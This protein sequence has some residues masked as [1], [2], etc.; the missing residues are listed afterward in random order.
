MG[1]ILKEVKFEFLKFSMTE[2][3]NVTFKYRWLFNR[4]TPW[5]SLSVYIIAADLEVE[6]D[7]TSYDIVRDF[8]NRHM[9]I[10]LWIFFISSNNYCP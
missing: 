2:Q 5:A 6:T 1:V 10:K 7:L 9:K 4:V 3:Q 8:K